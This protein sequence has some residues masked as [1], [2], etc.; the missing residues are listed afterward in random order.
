MLAVHL[1]IPFQ[2]Y[3]SIFFFNSNL[4][5]PYSIDLSFIMKKKWKD[6]FEMELLNVQL[7]L[8]INCILLLGSVKIVLI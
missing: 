7:T 1:K 3:P 6:M 2:T 8:N 4:Q 5:V